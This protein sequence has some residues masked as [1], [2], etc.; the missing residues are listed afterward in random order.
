MARPLDL[1]WRSRPDT[2]AAQ[3]DPRIRR[4]P[5]ARLLARKFRDLCLTDPNEADRYQIW[6]MQPQVGKSTWGSVWGPVW[7]LD[8]HPEWNIILTSYSAKLARRNARNARNIIRDHARHLRVALAPDTMSAEEWYTTAGGGVLSAGVDGSITGFKGDL[9]V[10]D[11]PH[12]NRREA[13]S[14]HMR[15]LVWDW[16]LDDVQSR[17]QGQERVLIPMTRWHPDDIVGRLVAEDPEKW[18]VTHLPALADPEIIDPDPIGRAPGEALCPEMFTVEAMHNRRKAVGPIGFAALYQGVPVLAEGDILKRSWWRLLLQP[19]PR[20]FGDLTIT[21]W[22][23]AGGDDGDSW[24][25]GQVWQVDTHNYERKRRYICI[26]Q[27]RGK[28]N[29]PEQKQMVLALAERHPQAS[30]HLIE[31]AS[32]GRAVLQDLAGKLSG[33]EPIN[34]GALGSKVDRAI[35]TTGLLKDGDIWLPNYLPE[36]DAAG[37]PCW[38]DK[39]IDEAA[40]FPGGTNDDMVDTYSQ[41][42]NWLR[43]PIHGGDASYSYEAGAEDYR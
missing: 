19:V 8:W 10:I 41:A 43:N 24:T 36:Y 1:A 9:I 17:L 13:N 39:L 22:D 21:S 31:N 6:T 32:N 29:L 25:V 3:I 4:H 42:I 30:H 33:L 2:L 7:A 23:M 37:E 27:V 14:K 12:K 20:S 16:W 38:V 18:T 40:D 15:D 35:S 5:H 34:P 11:D 28:W 26:D